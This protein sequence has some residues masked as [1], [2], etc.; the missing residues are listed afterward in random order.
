MVAV[1]LRGALEGSRYFFVGLP[2]IGL[3][4]VPYYVLFKVRSLVLC[5]GNSYDFIQ[6]PSFSEG[7]FVF[8]Q[9]DNLYHFL[10][11]SFSSQFYHL[12]LHYVFRLVC[13][14]ACSHFKLYIF[15]RVLIIQY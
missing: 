3:Q 7:S 13:I 15:F 9:L 11:S 5:Y 10:L 12:I 1:A 2:F 14:Y 6:R 4:L 8:G